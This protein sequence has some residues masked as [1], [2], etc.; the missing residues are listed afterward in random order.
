[1]SKILIVEDDANLRDLLVLH[2][3]YAGFET[4]E[5]E[6]AEGA[7]DL[8]EPPNTNNIDAI[9]LDWM[10]PG[11]SGVE[12]LNQLRQQKR[13]TYLPVLMLTAK[14]TEHDKVEGLSSGAD[15]YLT[16]PFSTAELVAR[17]HALLRRSQKDESSIHT[18]GALIVN[19]SDGTISFDGIVLDLTR[20]EYDLLNFLIQNQDRIYSRND[21]LDHVWGEEFFGTERTVDQHIAQLRSAIG[22][23]YIETVRGR[24]Y[25][26]VN[27]EST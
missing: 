19:S 12:W 4:I 26:F 14:A 20:R 27:P 23:D 6:T 17:M 2:L 5:S 8:L 7:W 15:D 18:V 3:E 10:L 24:G 16:K 11:T 22:A 21:L 25:C 9:I 13:F 1:M